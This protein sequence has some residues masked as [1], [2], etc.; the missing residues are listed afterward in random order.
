MRSLPSSS[1]LGK[2]IV[3]WKGLHDALPAKRRTLR[4][5]KGG[6]RSSHHIS[7]ISLSRRGLVAAAAVFAALVSTGGWQGPARAQAVP[8]WQEL[9]AATYDANCAACHLISGDRVPGTVPPL[10]GHLPAIAAEGHGRYYLIAVLL[11]GLE[12]PIVVHGQTYDG[13]M[14]NWESLAD[15][16]IA[17]VL[18]HALTAW[19]NDSDLPKGFSIIL[20]EEVAAGRPELRDTSSVHA[21]REALALP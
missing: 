19:G 9:G 12:G 6:V 3:F 10:A 16:E 21:L 1:R 15:E 7:P 11:F 4:R 20:P 14:P 17:A 13:I 5:K 18:N 2:Q 8:S